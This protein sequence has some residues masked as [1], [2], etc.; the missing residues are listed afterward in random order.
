MLLVIVLTSTYHLFYFFFRHRSGR[1]VGRTTG[2]TGP[3]ISGLELLTEMSV[4]VDQWNGS[5][6]LPHCCCF[7]SC[8]DVYVLVS[9]N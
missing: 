6:G 9:Q 3:V 8:L 2:E 1:L 5:I 7:K 4:S